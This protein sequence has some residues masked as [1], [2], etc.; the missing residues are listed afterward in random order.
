M[1]G[2]I[3][4]VRLREIAETRDERERLVGAEEGERE[5]DVVE[6]GE[7]IGGVQAWGDGVEEIV[8]AGGGGGVGVCEETGVALERRLADETAEAVVFAAVV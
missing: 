5:R 3:R 8:D 7:D 2:Q 1:R 6:E 4:L